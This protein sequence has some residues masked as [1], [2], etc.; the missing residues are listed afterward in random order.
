MRGSFAVV[1]VFDREDC[2]DNRE[3]GNGAVGLN[4]GALHIE[5]KVTTDPKVPG[6]RYDGITRFFEHPGNPFGPGAIAPRIADEKILH[7]R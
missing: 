3:D 6:L 5:H 4:G 2:V 7:V 1:A